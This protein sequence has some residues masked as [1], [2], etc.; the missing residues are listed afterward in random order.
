MKGEE[1]TGKY[2]NDTEPARYA[3]QTAEEKRD[4]P[5]SSY[6]EYLGRSG[7]CEE[8]KV[9]DIALV[10]FTCCLVI[11]GWFTIRSGERTTR[12]MERAYMFSGPYSP[13]C[14][15]TKTITHLTLENFG[16]SPG[17]LKEAYGEYSATEPTGNPVYKHGSA[18]KFDSAVAPTE[19]RPP[20]QPPPTIPTA[21]ESPLPGEQYFFGY[22]KYLDI[23][24]VEHECRFCTKIFP[25]TRKADLAG[26]EA[27]NDW[28]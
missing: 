12:D 20:N 22:I 24:R 23:F 17:I 5:K 10:F 7:F 4:T 14:T 28:N 1:T 11:V 27:W 16:R 19:Q 15:G 6:R 26:P 21:W 8:A 18:R 25:N 9:T 2:Q 13:V 3:Q